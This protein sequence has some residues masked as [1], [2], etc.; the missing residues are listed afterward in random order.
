[1]G[2]TK[3]ITERISSATGPLDE[4]RLAPG[5]HSQESDKTIEFPDAVLQRGS[6]EAPPV[7][8]LQFEAS[9]CSI[10][11]ALFDVVR[12]VKLRGIEN[13]HTTEYENLLQSLGSTG[14][15]EGATSP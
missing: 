6:R 5:Y 15:G 11:R 4:T 3:V 1:M 10:G 9:L 8:A 13:K 2:R 7:S 12:F 14:S